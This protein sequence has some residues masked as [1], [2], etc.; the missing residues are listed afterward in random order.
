VVGQQ[1][2]GLLD[3]EEHPFEVD[4]HD[5]VELG[6]GDVSVRLERSDA[7][8]GEDT[9]SRPCRSRAA[10]PERSYP[11]CGTTTLGE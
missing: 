3:G 11:G 10:R 6:L 7:R 5:P 4:V 1:R 8:V 9:S 2:H